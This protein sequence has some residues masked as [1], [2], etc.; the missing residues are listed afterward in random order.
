MQIA[1]GWE[2]RVARNLGH[3]SPHIKQRATAVL[4][5]KTDTSTIVKLTLLEDLK[6]L[7]VSTSVPSQEP[8]QA[9]SIT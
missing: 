9:I 3:L 4:L 2:E 1:N 5:R 7:R 6:A 8:A